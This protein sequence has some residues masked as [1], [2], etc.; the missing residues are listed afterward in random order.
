MAG[1]IE[2]RFAAE[3]STETRGQSR[4]LIGYAARYGAV[5]DIGGRFREKIAPGAFAGSLR[6][7]SGES[8]DIVA[9]LDHDP[10]RILGRTRSKTLTLADEEDGLYFDI[11]VPETT[12]G[13][14]ALA[15]AERG[16]LGGASI[17]FIVEEEA[18][19]KD[20][21]IVKRARLLEI[22]IVSSWPAYGGTTVEARER[23]LAQG[24]LQ[25]HPSRPRL[26][27]LRNYLETL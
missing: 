9:L 26:D 20:V 1:E 3:I 15:L 23:R 18:R 2:K 8:E 19:E 21:R 27:A 22:S 14:D 13:R 4:R 24:R 25:G 7:G 16:D 12:A 6:T 17:G 11:A 5:A 10:S